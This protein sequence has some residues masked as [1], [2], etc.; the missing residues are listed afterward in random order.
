MVRTYKRK[1]DRADRCNTAI[2]ELAA[3][4][5]IC[6]KESLRRVAKDYQI[7]FM[8][9]H[10]YCKN[11]KGARASPISAGYKQPR[12]IFSPTHEKLLVEYILKASKIYYG[13]T[14]K[15]VR[16]F[17][18]E[19]AV[20]NIIKVPT[21]WTRT[22]MA[23]PDWFSCF[24]KR[25]PTLSL[26]T[27][28]ATSLSRATSFNRHN[29]GLFFNKLGEVL[30]RHKFQ[31]HDIYNIDETGITTVQKPTRIVAGKGAKQVGAMT[32]GERGALVT[33]VTAISA[34]GNT[35]PPMFVFPRVNFRDHFIRDGPPGCIGA[36]HQSGW[37][38]GENFIIFMKHFVSV[39]RCTKDKPVLI[40]L[41]NH[42]SHVS[43]ELID[44]CRDNGVVLVTFPPHCSHRLQPLD[45]S[46]YGP[47]KST[48]MNHVTAG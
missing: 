20:S 12:L 10:R 18:Y 25:N 19:F 24:M 14:P 31:C 5:V 45:V 26:R 6:H 46:V 33:L 21:N 3:E 43:L 1:T 29:V 11:N 37:M 34:S 44:Y 32:S 35:V 4:R 42:D 8:T 15:E 9:L 7:S 13:L 17:A 16:A 36:A 23:G 27:P 48:L 41:D 2:L 40:L 22:Q 30:Q 38:T 28:E 47:F 39:T